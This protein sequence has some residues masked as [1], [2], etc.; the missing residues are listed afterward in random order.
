VPKVLRRPKRQRTYGDGTELDGIDDLPTDREKEG[1]FRVMPKGYGNRVPGGTYSSKTAGD[2]GT[3]RKKGR[4]EGP[5]TSAGLCSFDAVTFV[6]SFDA[7]IEP[8]NHSADPP[9]TSTT[10]TLNR[11][12]RIDFPSVKSADISVKKKKKDVSSPISNTTRRK[13]TL[14]RN[15]GGANAPKGQCN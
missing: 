13:P 10:N 4:R 8:G 7:D 12:G 5:E 6:F 11:T 2:K 1:R 14:I 15:L 9:L 3:I